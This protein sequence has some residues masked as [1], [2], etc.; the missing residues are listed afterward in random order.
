MWRELSDR[1]GFVRRL[2]Y[3]VGWWVHTRLGWR[4]GLALWG[5][6]IPKEEFGEGS[7]DGEDRSWN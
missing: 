5:W 1:A 7:D 2:A 4:W 3:C 6:S